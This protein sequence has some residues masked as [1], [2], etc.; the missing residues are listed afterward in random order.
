MLKKMEQG[1]MTLKEQIATAAET[2]LAATPTGLTGEA[3][4]GLVARQVKRQ[5]PLAQVTAVLRELPQRFVEQDGGRWQLRPQE[6]SLLP[7]DTKASS[8]PSASP[9]Q[10]LKQG[11]YVVFDLEATRQD[12]YSPAT[13]IIQIAA[14][15]WVDGVPQDPWASFVRPTIPEGLRDFFNYVGDLPLIAHNGAS[16]DGPL[17]KATSERLGLPLL[18]TFRVLDTLPLA[19]V[20]LPCADSHRVGSLAEHYGCARPDAHRADADVEMLGGI[21]RGLERDIQDGPSGAAVYD[22]LRRAGDPWAEVLAPPSHPDLVAEVTAT[23]GANL[24]PLLPE[25]LPATLGPIDA[26]VVESTFVRAEELGHTR[27]EAQIEM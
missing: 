8:S 24:T 1:C 3:L 6:I 17:L 15:R 12:A 19:R 14:Q 7:E 18:P 25:R 26:S 16:Y 21:V 11:C 10:P 4:T 27:R 2:A 5:I 13:E 22:L 20:L 23:F 9:S